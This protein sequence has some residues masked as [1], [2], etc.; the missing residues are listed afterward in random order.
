MTVY[1]NGSALVQRVWSMNLHWALVCLNHL[2]CFSFLSFC[3]SHCKNKC[4]NWM[5]T[6]SPPAHCLCWL[7]LLIWSG[8]TCSL[9]IMS[10]S[11]DGVIGMEG[12]LF[13]WKTCFSSSLKNWM[14]KMGSRHKLSCGPCWLLL[15]AWA[16]CRWWLQRIPWERNSWFWWSKIFNWKIC[17]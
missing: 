4:K 10:G 5:H 3:S 9:Q 15:L 1:G 6:L 17:N 7:F 8:C 11:W 2:E 12:A 14:S 13:N 16:G